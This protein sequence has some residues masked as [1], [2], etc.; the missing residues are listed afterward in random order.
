M[1][2][3]RKRI[4]R[5][6][7]P[8]KA[9]L[10]IYSVF[11]IILGL[12]GIVTNTIDYASRPYLQ[13][14]KSILRD[15]NIYYVHAGPNHHCSISITT[16]EDKYHLNP[17]YLTQSIGTIEGQMN[18]LIGKTIVIEYE[19]RT[20]SIYG[21]RHDNNTY[22]NS[23]ESSII[24][25]KLTIGSLCVSFVFLALGTAIVAIGTVGRNTKKRNR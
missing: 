7:K 22:V 24:E 12:H 18:D 17:E 23:I 1:I 15:V 8:S 20:Y 16:D 13:T 4:K 10:C 3:L 19:P 5:K 14:E 9:E 21:I 25:K 11:L 2:E 6:K